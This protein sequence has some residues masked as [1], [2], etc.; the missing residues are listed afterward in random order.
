MW[1]SARFEA[2]NIGFFEI[3]VYLHGKVGVEPV[4]AF[5]GQRGK[6]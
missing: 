4:W 5:C 1:I 6:A 3:T 2:I